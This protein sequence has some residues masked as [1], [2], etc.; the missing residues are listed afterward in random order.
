MVVPHKLVATLSGCAAHPRKIP[1]C[2]TAVIFA[3][4]SGNPVVAF[5]ILQFHKN[6]VALSAETT[7]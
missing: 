2:G 7:V 1:L 5:I 4:G 6:D 3:V